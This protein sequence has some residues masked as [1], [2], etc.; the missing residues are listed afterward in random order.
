MSRRDNR[1]KDVWLT[2]ASGGWWNSREVFINVPPRIEMTQQNVHEALHRMVKCG[3]LVK[4]G[5]KRKE[6]AV[7]PECVVPHGLR[8]EQVQQAIGGAR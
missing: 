6:Y 5:D 1:W 8:V 4:R 3:H 7:T 2:I